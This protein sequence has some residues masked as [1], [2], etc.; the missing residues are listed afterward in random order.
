LR[1]SRTLKR[2]ACGLGAIITANIA[3]ADPSR[4]RWLW[5]RTDA[6]MFV[7][8][9]ARGEILVA[10]RL[11]AERSSVTTVQRPHRA[12]SSPA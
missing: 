3:L 1:G 6:S 8:R 5:R 9:W 10:S 4:Q 7:G 11:K 2:I 12:F